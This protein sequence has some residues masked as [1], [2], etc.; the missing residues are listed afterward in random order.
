[1]AE[2]KTNAE[3][4]AQEATSL[5]SFNSININGI[6]N[7]LE[8]MLAQIGKNGIFDEY[9]KHD[10]SH[11]DTM[12]NIAEMLI[13]KDTKNK[14][15]SADWLLLVLSIYFHDLGMLVTKSEYQKKNNNTDYKKFE[16]DYLN[17][18]ANEES[19]KQLKS[20]NKERFIYQEYVR[21]N[22]G[23]RIADWLKN[24]NVELYDEQVIS[25]VQNMIKGL[26]PIFIKDISIICESHNEDDL[27][28]NDKYPIRQDYG[29]SP[30][31]KG[32]VFYVALIL[33]TADLLHMTDNRTPSEEFQIISPSNPI[34]QI[35]WAKQSSVTSVSPKDQID[36]EGNVD[37]TKQSDT[38]SITGY[39]EDP[40]GFFPLMDYIGYV[41]AQLQ[42]SY[43]LN[44][45]KKKRFSMEYDFPWKDIDDKKIA[46][47]DY[48]RHQ[49]SFTIDQQKILDL[50]VGETLYNN[51]TV[52]LREIVQNAIDAVKVKKYELDEKKDYSYKPKVVVCWYP[53]TRQL[54]V[55]DNGIGMDIDIIRKH[56]LTVG[57]S[58]YRDKD[59]L[60]SHTGFNSISRFGIGLLTCFMVAEDV[61]ILTNMGTSTKPLLLKLSKLHGKYLLK[62]GRE[63]DSP[64][65]LLDKDKSGTSIMLKILPDIDFNPEK[66][67]HEWI[68]FPSCDFEFVTRN[69]KI[70]IGYDNTKSLI[71]DVLHKKGVSADGTDYKIIGTNDNGLDFS[72]LLK[73][74]K[75]IKDWSFVDYSDIFGDENTDVVPCGLSIEGIRIDSNTPGFNTGYFIAMVNLTGKNAPLTNVARSAINSQSINNALSRI[76]NTYL[77]EIN[78]QIKILSE[79]YSPTWALSELPFLLGKFY[80]DDRMVANNLLIDKNI[81]NVSLKTKPFFLIEKDDN[82]KFVSLDDLKSSN[83]FWIIDS[84]AYYSATSLIREVKSA[85]VSI[86]ELLKNLYGTDKKILEDIDVVLCN[87]RSKNNLDELIINEFEVT[88]IRIYENHRTLLLLW[89]AKDS[90]TSNK[91]F[92]VNIRTTK[93]QYI[94]NSSHTLFVQND[95]SVKLTNCPYEGVASEYGLFILNGSEIH[96]YLKDL[97]QD[98]NQDN[99]TRKFVKQAVCSFISNS[100]G[101]TQNKK[102]KSLF[103]DYIEQYYNPRFHSIIKENIDIEKLVAACE[104]SKFTLYDKLMWYRWDSWYME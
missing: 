83:H 15:T 45:E 98:Y 63:K 90:K 33:R 48:E 96:K 36:E 6:K 79:E 11:V 25:L 74:N 101:K 64:L 42:T 68:L 4:L 27:D 24:E 82:K 76:Y 31:E 34:S 17:K 46:T 99:D 35:E 52:A 87:R 57:S 38:L 18:T 73:R 93:R 10:I 80:N 94:D 104:S 61:D 7:S 95:N 89:E 28:N 78:N 14:M 51:S 20:E 32:N 69:N 37:K 54:I 60:K 16:N 84:A 53:D 9:T 44:E 77:D 50:L 86:V 5:T 43:K 26:K 75:Y 23:K 103:N 29:M 66:I 72:I 56:L 1:M 91:W 88:D 19:L 67:L 30:Q 2:L 47:K 85:N 39:F 100:F 22:H 3:K 92:N 12:L 62:Y 8:T 49:L 59:F 55:S 58:R 41:K 13:P 97:L 21:K 71:D 81:F 40:K 102:W 70:T 65:D